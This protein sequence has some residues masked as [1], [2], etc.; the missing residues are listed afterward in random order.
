MAE[1]A[2]WYVLKVVSGQE[3]K[4]KSHL[5]T[6]LTQQKLDAAIT[7]ILIPSEKVYGMRA[8]KKTIKERNFFPGYVLICAALL[9]GKVL[10][11]VKDTPGALGFLSTRGWGGNKPPVPLSQAEVSR[12]L[13]RED[14]AEEGASLNEGAKFTLGETIQVIDGPFSG[15]SGTIQEVFEERK[16]LNVTVKIF[17]RDTPIELGYSQVE[18]TK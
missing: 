13:G 8:G 4:V 3:K 15:F 1:L 6:E 10:H 11:L 12:I 5:E 18:E 17:E 2:S 14:G 9:D 7:Q 16:K